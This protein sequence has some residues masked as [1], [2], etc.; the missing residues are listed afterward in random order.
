MLLFFFYSHVLFAPSA[1]NAYAGSSFPGLVDALYSVQYLDDK[2]W[3]LVKK[4]LSVATFYIQSAT[5]VMLSE[6]L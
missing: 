2:D 6:S 5:N 1:H 3:E 4:E